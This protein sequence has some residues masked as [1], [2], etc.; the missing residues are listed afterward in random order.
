MRRNETKRRERHRHEGAPPRAQTLGTDVLLRVLDE[1]AEQVRLLALVSLGPSSP[2]PLDGL[3]AGLL[4]DLHLASDD[5]L[6][7]DVQEAL[8]LPQESRPEESLIGARLHGVECDGEWNRRAVAEAAGAVSEC[9]LAERVEC[10]PEEQVLRVEHLALVGAPPHAVE[11]VSRVPSQHLRHVVL[12]TPSREHVR[13]HLALLLPH[14]TVGVEDAATEKDLHRRTKEVAL[15][16][17][18]ASGEGEENENEKSRKEGSTEQR[19]SSQTCPSLAIA[20][21]ADLS[22]TRTPS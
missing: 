10:E 6:G 19:L 11:D 20:P 22:P 13:R 8:Q 5:A 4:D 12:E 2:G 14:V 17:F 7:A 15:L 16:I 18:P 9:D 21:T 1:S 3:E